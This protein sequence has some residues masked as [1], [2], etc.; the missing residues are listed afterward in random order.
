MFDLDLNMLGSLCKSLNNFKVV[1]IIRLNAPFLHE[2]DNLLRLRMSLTL[3]YH[4]SGEFTTHKPKL[5]VTPCYQF[6][7]S[8]CKV[9]H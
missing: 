2:L 6:K 7:L 8:N 4:I 1:L 9:S 5:F 3:N